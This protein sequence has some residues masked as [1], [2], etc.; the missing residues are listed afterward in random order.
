MSLSD[1][2]QQV[3]R[4]VETRSGIPVH[5]EA[6]PN[7]PG[8]ILAKVVMARGPLALHQVF[9][10]PNSAST[11]DYLICR[12]AGFILRVFDAPTEKR[13]DFTASAEGT[14]AVE[15]LVKAHSVAK[16]VPSQALP[17]L[18]LML[19]D[20]LLRHLRSIPVGM[21]VDCWLASEYPALAQLQKASILREIQDSVATLAPLHRQTAPQEIFDATQ[22][23]STAFA[24]FWAGRLDQPQL[25]LPFKA[26]GYL[27]AGQELLSI[28]ESTP[29]AAE[30]DPAMI[31]AWAKNLGIA[32]WYQW[33]PYSAPK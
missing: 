26:A 14:A 11:P 28:W 3:L 18:C 8:T 20:G 33:V 29:D 24:A 22:A 1:I 31:D 10:R 19:R 5:V 16:A 7:L 23:I 9:Y 2:T 15:R 32:G 17:Q 21:R 6:D 13:L 4:L 27:Q 12:Q 30:N 25:A